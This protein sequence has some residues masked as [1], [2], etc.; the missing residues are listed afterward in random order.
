MS[1]R[2]DGWA[3]HLGRCL[4][5]WEIV[6]HKGVR[7]KGRENRS[8]NLGDNL[9][10]NTDME[11]KQLTMLETRIRFLEGQIVR[12]QAQLNRGTT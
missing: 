7:F 9:Q 5:S 10:L 11:H 8:D 4:Q 6:H 12:L 1:W 3:K 2:P